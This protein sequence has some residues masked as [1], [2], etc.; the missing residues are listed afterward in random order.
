M[1]A[2]THWRGC[3]ALLFVATTLACQGA[4][5]AFLKIEGVDGESKDSKHARWI[6]VSSFTHGVAGPSTNSPGPTFP[7]LCLAK[8]L[9]KSSPVLA[10]RCA[11]GAVIPS[12]RLE[13]IT[14]DARRLRFYQVALSNV[15][16]TSVVTAGAALD[17]GPTDTVCLNF[18]RIEWVY[19]E[20]ELDGLPKGDQQSWW[21]LVANVGGGGAV[22]ALRV[23][24]APVPGGLFRLSWTG[25]SGRTYS[26]RSSPEVAGQFGVVGRVSAV[27]DGPLTY[28][29]PPAGGAGF[30]QLEES[31]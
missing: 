10:Q 6:D 12:A 23:T 29:L 15:V 31:Q 20:Y 19:T 16:V 3:A 22:P 1:P 21:D 4:F 17:G 26:I 5:D 24:G 7:P 13:L 9:D 27:V 11:S 18:G 8:L 28:D 25:R 14:R 2:P 30:F